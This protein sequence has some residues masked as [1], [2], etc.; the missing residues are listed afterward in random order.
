MKLAERVAL[1]V[2]CDNATPGPWR[3]EAGSFNGKSGHIVTAAQPSEAWSK[4]PIL[5]SHYFYERDRADLALI[6]AA[7]TAI[8]ALLA[9]VDRLH[10]LIENATNCLEAR[11]DR[12]ARL[13]W[14]AAI[15][16]EAG[17]VEP[18]PAP[19]DGIDLANLFTAPA[20]EK[21]RPL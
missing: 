1:Q 14:A 3:F 2:L 9:E 5:I 20:D 21:G 7:P 15:R 18:A 10:K 4:R 12:A 13:E 6:A 8:P 16:V 11:S 17:N 19:L